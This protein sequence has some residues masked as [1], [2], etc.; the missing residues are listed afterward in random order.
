M[1]KSKQRIDRRNRRFKTSLELNKKNG[2]F[3]NPKISHRD[4]KWVPKVINR[5]GKNVRTKVY[6]YLDEIKK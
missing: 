5:K 6:V 4:G 1:T 3:G 2:T